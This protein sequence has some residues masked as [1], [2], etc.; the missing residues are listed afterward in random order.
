[1]PTVSCSSFDS[2]SI[3]VKLFFSRIK[4]ECHLGK[5]VLQICA[6]YTKDVFGLFN[7]YS[8][9]LKL[10]HKGG[11]KNENC[12]ALC[13]KKNRTR[14]FLRLIRFLLSLGIGK[15]IAFLPVTS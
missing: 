2:I 11:G 3:D 13:P 1:M 15:S 12:A 4:A 10:I 7:S 9:L 5:D 6:T 14:K 8:Y